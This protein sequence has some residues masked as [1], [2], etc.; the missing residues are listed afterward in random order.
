M[1]K[2]IVNKPKFLVIHHT[3]GTDLDPLFDTSN[4]SFDVVNRYH[5]ERFGND[6]KSS[7]GFYIGYHYFIDK[8]GLVTRG[9]DDEDEG[10]HCNQIQ[11]GKSMNLQSIGIC[12][13]GNF[14]ATKPT[15]AQVASLK[16]LLNDK[17]Q[18][19]NIPVTNIYPHRHW[20]PKTC[21]GRHLSESWARDLIK[22]P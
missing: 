15:D 14:D 13:A 16:Q 4:Q 2:K 6:V 3:G 22:T 11:D 8:A 18:Q 21:Y 1:V 7:L 12:L 19:W 9:R 17:H 20:A 10:V 5:R